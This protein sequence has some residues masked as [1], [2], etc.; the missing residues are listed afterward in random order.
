MHQADV[1]IVGAE[2]ATEAVKI[3]AHAGRVACPGFCQHGDFVALYVLESFGDVRMAS[4]G[5]GSVEEAEAMI[6][7]VEQ[8]IGETFDAERGLMRVV[9]GTNGAGA[10]GEAAGLDAGA[11]ESDGV[12]G[13]EFR[14][15]SLFGD[16]VEDGCGTEPGC[17]QAGGGANEEFA[18][19]HEVLLKFFF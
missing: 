19:T 3:G 2:L 18:A 13:G 6:V 12:G 8:K 4:I 7:S 1:E 11:A 5:V 14:G 9:L 16:G 10:H 15:E 17:S